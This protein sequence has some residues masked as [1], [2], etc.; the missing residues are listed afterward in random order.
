[1][2]ATHC[3]D[4]TQ[5]ADHRGLRHD[6]FEPGPVVVRLHGLAAS[7]DPE[8]ALSA[9]LEQVSIYASDQYIDPSAIAIGVDAGPVCPRYAWQQRGALL[10]H[11]PLII[12]LADDFVD[13]LSANGRRHDVWRAIWSLRTYSQ[14]YVA[15][16]NWVTSPSPALLAEKADAVQ[17]PNLL[18]VPAGTAWCSVD[19]ALNECTVRKGQ[20]DEDEL[21]QRLVEAIDSA[22]REHDTR[23]W[24]TPTIQNDSIMNRRL[25]IVLSGVGDLVDACGWDPQAFNTLSTLNAL[26]AALKREALK[27]STTIAR[28]RG[29]CPSLAAIG[30]SADVKWQSKWQQLLSQNT[31]AHRNLIVM[32]PETVLPRGTPVRPE[33]ADLLPLLTHS[34]ASQAVPIAGIA[35]WNFNDFKHFHSRAWAVLD[36][37]TGQSLI[38]ETG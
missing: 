32:S 2:V 29:H 3:L 11:G 33:Y 1:M 37:R 21:Q 27:H 12:F 38:A 19:V 16:G 14:T 36:R 34:D 13:P 20:V 8:Q 22:D 25:A 35:G 28:A 5:P 31:V 30:W 6:L 24:P 10:G 15:Y 9:A 18:Q 17:L 26:L 23:R 7:P 4:V